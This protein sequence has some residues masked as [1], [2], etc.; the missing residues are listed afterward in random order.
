MQNLT[1]KLITPLL[2]NG[3]S[4]IIQ[5]QTEN[6]REAIDQFPWAMHFTN[7]DVNEKVNLFNPICSG[8]PRYLLQCAPLSVF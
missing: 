1:L 5:K 8:P 7:I 3:K 6:I 2:M 4:G